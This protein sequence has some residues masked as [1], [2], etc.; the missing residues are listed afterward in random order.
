MDILIYLPGVSK[1]GVRTSNELNWASYTLE[2]VSSQQM[3]QL[4]VLSWQ[5][6][7]VVA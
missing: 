3:K 2:D 1:P 6:A 5:V 7:E 4:R